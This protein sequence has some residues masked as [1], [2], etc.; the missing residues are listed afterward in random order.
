MLQIML[1]GLLVVV[2]YL[3]SHLLVTRAE[4]WVGV[5]LGHWRTA[6]FFVVFLGLLLAGLELLPRFFPGMRQGS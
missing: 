1:L 5:P 4:R 6:I 2:V 3:L